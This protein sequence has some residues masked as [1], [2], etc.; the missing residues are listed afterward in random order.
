MERRLADITPRLATPGSQRRTKMESLLRRLAQEGK[1]RAKMVRAYITALLGKI[2]TRQH[3][4]TAVI[5][6]VSQNE[7]A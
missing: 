7:S 2:V 1:P 6:V 5:E 4:T 3:I